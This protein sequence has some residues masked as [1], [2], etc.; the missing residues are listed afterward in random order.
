MPTSW[1]CTHRRNVSSVD[2]LASSLTSPYGIRRRRKQLFCTFFNWY[3]G[4][5]QL[6]FVS[7]YCLETQG[8]A[9]PLFLRNFNDDAINSN[10][11]VFVHM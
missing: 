9:P 4:S 3:C 6:A 10:I 5:L 8:E 2:I 7:C 1:K 11:F